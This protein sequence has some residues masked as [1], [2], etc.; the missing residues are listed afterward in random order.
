MIARLS[1]WP[2]WQYWMLLGASLLGVVTITFVDIAITDGDASFADAPSI[3]WLLLGLGTICLLGFGV[4]LHFLWRVRPLLS[5]TM[6]FFSLGTIMTFL[7][8]I[9]SDG[10]TANTVGSAIVALVSLLVAAVVKVMEVKERKH[11]SIEI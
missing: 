5:D 3:Y 8:M 7:R 6:A 2:L 9:W 10:W 11:L 1:N 4:S